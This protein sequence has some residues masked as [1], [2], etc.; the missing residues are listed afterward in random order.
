MLAALPALL[1]WGAA[2]EAQTLSTRSRSDLFSSQTALMDR[3]LSGQYAHSRRLVPTV[4]SAV[5]VPGA[6]AI[7]RYD[8]GQRSAWIET[9]RAAARRNGVPEDLFLCLVR[10]E[11]GWNPNAQ[12]RKG[13][14]GL[15]QLMPGTA[16]ALG[17][18]PRNPAQNLEGGA[19]YLAAQYRAF[20]SWRLALAAY[21][22]GP[23]AVQRHG[24]VPPY[25][26]TRNYVAVIL[27]RG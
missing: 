21:N 16:R 8:G 1:V 25:K 6:E 26:E 14:L 13:A 20:G 24:G 9:A 17:V 3:R 23:G 4:P 7:P 12:S 22:A 18:D 27:G 10:Q 15:A 2:A 5:R 11:S 19:R